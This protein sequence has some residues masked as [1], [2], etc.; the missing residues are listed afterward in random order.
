MTLERSPDASHTNSAR[1]V[2]RPRLGGILGL[3]FGIVVTGAIV[4]L[5]FQARP[6][7]K[8]GQTPT[9][10]AVSGP[11]LPGPIG[12]PSVAMDVN[13]LVGKPAPNFTLSN[14][15]GVAY[16]ISPGGGTPLVLIFNMGIT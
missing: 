2:E 16:P 15:E 11:T 5:A 3:V 13:T 9:S 7:S 10:V 6:A 4:I 14:S 1:G 12:G 8:P